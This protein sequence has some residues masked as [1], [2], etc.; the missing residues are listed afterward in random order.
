MESRG[1]NLVVG[2]LVVMVAVLAGYIVTACRE[3]QPTVEYSARYYLE[4]AN[5]AADSARVR[6]DF[7]GQ[8]FE[9]TT[10]G[11]QRSRFGSGIIALRSGERR[12]FKMTVFGPKDSPEDN[13]FLTAFGSIYFFFDANSGTPYRS[14][15][16]PIGGCG[17]APGCRDSSDE[18]RIYH[19]HPDGTKERLFV[20][21]SDRPFYLERDKEDP[22]L[23]RI[24]ITFVPDAEGG[25]ED[26]VE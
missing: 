11:V 14:Y 2:V 3:A 21:S 24:V 26:A 16:Y 23:R 20:E 4:V 15:E 6:I 9:D 7:D 25:P 17:D 8:D 10:T 18:T 12:K 22:E 1:A 5:D 13:L 19:R